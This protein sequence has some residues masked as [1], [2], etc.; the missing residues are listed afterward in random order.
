MGKEMYHML[1]IICV[2]IDMEY[3][4]FYNYTSA[5]TLSVPK[6]SGFNKLNIFGFLQLVNIFKLL[7]IRSIQFV[8][9]VD[10]FS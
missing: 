2:R 9:L 1:S 5:L 4:T 3:R 10:L 7:G 6:N 8:K